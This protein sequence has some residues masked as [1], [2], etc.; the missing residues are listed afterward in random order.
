MDSCS[1]E[2]S[3]S[4]DSPLVQYEQHLNVNFDFKKEFQSKEEIKNAVTLYHTLVR[5]SFKIVASD[6]R[7]YYVGCPAPD[8][9]FEL[10]FSFLN[11]KFKG[12]N[13]FQRHTCAF[14]HTVST[15]A[16]H[17]VDYLSGLTAVREWMSLKKRAANTTDLKVLLSSL[18]HTEEYHTILRILNKLKSEFF[19]TDEQQ[20]TMLDS[21]AE[22]LNS[23]G[24][25]A[26]LEKD[27]NNVFKRMCIVF[28]E[29]I[30]KNYI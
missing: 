10:K 2:T 3:S 15:N 27:R 13:S 24:Q 26:T 30:I 29:G 4:D 16:T 25:H 5:R 19:A 21:Y 22:V 28:R 23:K 14:E 7:R 17:K 1:E 6:T 11:D 9:E 8:C 20:Y 18:G 12:A